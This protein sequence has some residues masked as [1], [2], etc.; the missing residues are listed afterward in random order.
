MCSDDRSGWIVKFLRKFKFVA[1]SGERIGYATVNMLLKLKFDC[2]IC[3][4]S[5]LFRHYF[6]QII[7][8]NPM[9]LSNKYVMQ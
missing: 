4:L 8:V 2:E 3:A 7:I 1:P 9:S 5:V 6:I